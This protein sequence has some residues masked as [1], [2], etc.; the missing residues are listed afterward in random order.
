MAAISFENQTSLQQ[1]HPRVLAGMRP[2]NIDRSY[3]QICPQEAV[4]SALEINVVLNTI[5]SICRARDPDKSRTYIL[6]GQ[7][8][9]R[10]EVIMKTQQKETCIV[11]HDPV[12]GVFYGTSKDSIRFYRMVRTFQKPL[13]EKENS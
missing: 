13:S 3:T 12:L 6:W 11:G 4:S 7:N 5:K 9:E 8:N 10:C 2:S 1:Q